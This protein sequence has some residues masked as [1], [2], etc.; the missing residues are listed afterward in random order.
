MT[1]TKDAHYYFIGIGG[2]GMS[3]LA[4]ALHKKGIQVSGSDLSSGLPTQLL[5]EQGV[6]V[7]LGHHETQ[8]P[9]EAIVVVS[10]DIKGSNCELI[11]VQ[12]KGLQI[13]HRS[14]LLSLLMKQKRSIHVAGTHGKTTTSSLLAHVLHHAGVCDSFSLG[15]IPKAMGIHGALGEKPYFVAEVDE[16]DGSF[17]KHPGEYAIVTSLS[18]DH[19]DYWKGSSQLNDAFKQYMNQFDREKIVYCAD[20]KRLTDLNIP[21][22]TYGIDHGEWRIKNIQVE[23]KGS[24]FDLV[25]EKESFADFFVPLRGIHN[26]KNAAAVVLIAMK[27]QVPLNDIRQGLISFKGVRRRMD[28]VLVTETFSLYDDYGH[29]PREVATTVQGAALSFGKENLRVIF[30]P[31]RYTRLRDNWE[32]FLECLTGIE[33]LWVTD[34]YSAR[35]EPIEGIT[36]ERFMDDLKKRMSVRYVPRK[37]LA[38]ELLQEPTQKKVWLA[39]GAGSIVFLS[40]EIKKIL[41]SS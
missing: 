7:H 31:H 4:L 14:D 38:R 27:L 33:D 12:Q 8:V 37:D 41:E 26:V 18:D 6:V 5:K 32:N 25:S 1:L 23:A 28:K 30:E 9:L 39:I 15:G 16:S 22:T 20:E 19:L 3:S 40:S 11:S 35:E 36:I 21:G 34:I 13:L 24:F 17:L 29:H 2:I 10:T